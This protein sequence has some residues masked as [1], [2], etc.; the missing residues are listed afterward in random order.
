MMLFVNYFYSESFCNQCSVSG[1][2]DLHRDFN[3]PRD[4]P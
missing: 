3:Q 1:I 4:D 2:M